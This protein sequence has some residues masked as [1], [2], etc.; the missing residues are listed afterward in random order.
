METIAILLAAG[1]GSRFGAETNKVFAR[2]GGLTIL[3]RA[4]RSLFDHPAVASMIVVGA[5][6]EKETI[7]TLLAASFPGR[8]F[9]IVTGGPTRQSS[10]LAGLKAAR[11]LIG[12]DPGCRVGVLIHDA[13]RCFLGA[14]TVTELVDTIE[15]HRCGVAPALPVTD[16]IRLLDSTRAAVERTLP[17]E[18]LVA[19]QTPQGADLD[20]MYQAALL[21]DEE[22][23]AVTDDLE[24]LIR[25][26]FP[27]RL[28]A[29]DPFNIKVTRPEDIGLVRLDDRP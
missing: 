1:R 13:A 16:T 18:R 11:E 25:I 6:G 24:L 19:M 27:V 20:I 4:A 26:G 29:G 2:I 14:G 28:I 21:A 12:E 7:G 5:A 9:R 8:H 23:A 22:G 10:A 17:R 15:R 3:E